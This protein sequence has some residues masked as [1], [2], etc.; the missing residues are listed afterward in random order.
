MI[1]SCLRGMDELKAEV[2]NLS[3]QLERQQ[4]MME[5]WMKKVAEFE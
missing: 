4:K 1:Q 2:K 5:E 3:E